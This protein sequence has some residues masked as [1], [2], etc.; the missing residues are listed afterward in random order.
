MKK[1]IIIGAGLTGCT[2]AH[3]LGSSLDITIIEKN[4]RLGGHCHDFKNDDGVI[5]QE[6]GPHIF[7]TNHQ[8]AIDLLNKFTT[9]ND[10]IHKVKVV[11][12]NEEYDWPINLNTIN[13]VFNKNMSS[14]EAKL[15]IDKQINE[16]K[17][18]FDDSNFKNVMI[19][20]I[21][22]T[23]YDK[24]IN[25][26][27]KKQWGKD[28]SKLTPSFA[29]RIPI[30]YNYDDRFFVDKYQGIPVSGYYDMMKNM[31]DNKNI[32][33]ILRQEYK[34]FDDIYKKRDLL[35]VTSPIDE[36]FNY[37][38]GR[39]EYRGQNIVFESSALI[40]QK[41]AVYNYPN[42]N[43][44]YVRI[45]EMNQFYNNIGSPVV[46]AIEYPG[47]ASGYNKSYPMQDES[48]KMLYNKYVKLIPPNVIFAGRLGRFQY[49]NMDVAIKQAID[50]SK[51][52]LKSI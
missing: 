8:E 47:I 43:I 29:G 9:L 23:L 22:K 14:E 51:E 19:K 30:K 1:V 11:I 2:L 15:F 39:L 28:P 42:E 38:L 27:T 20:K 35:I 21:G 40:N 36:F 49:I 17:D 44:D 41:C 12:G 7:H 24:F 10:Y 50:L 25:G 4:K 16:V 34:T 3:L 6:F 37:Q 13:K 52:I 18:V 5:I 32:E 46:K 48:N 31:I 26:Y 33:L 45:T